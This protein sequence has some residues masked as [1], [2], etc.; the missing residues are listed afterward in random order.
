MQT[1]FQFET[2]SNQ[3]KLKL[4]EMMVSKIDTSAKKLQENI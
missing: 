4:I 1:E 2:V 3:I